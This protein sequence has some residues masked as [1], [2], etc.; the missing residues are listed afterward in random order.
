[1]S[2]F[3][4]RNDVDKKCKSLNSWCEQQAEIKNYI[5][6]KKTGGRISSLPSIG[7]KPVIKHNTEEKYGARRKIL[8][9]VFLV[10]G[11]YAKIIAGTKAEGIEDKLTRK[12]SIAY[13]R[14][15][16]MQ[17]LKNLFSRK[18]FIDRIIENIPFN[19][20][21]T[22]RFV[23]TIWAERYKLGLSTYSDWYTVPNSLNV[24]KEEFFNVIAENFK[25][26]YRGK[27]FLRGVEKHSKHDVVDF[28]VVVEVVANGI[29]VHSFGDRDKVSTLIE[30]IRENYQPIETLNVTSISGFNDKGPIKTFRSYDIDT[31]SFSEDCF[32]PWLGSSVKQFAKEYDESESSVLLLIGERG[33]GKSTF[34]RTLLKEMKRSRNYVISSEAALRS[35]HIGPWLDGLGI[36]NLVA[37]EDADNFISKREDG[38]LNMSQILNLTEGVMKSN[39]KIIFSTN[40][41]SLNKVDGALLREGRTFKILTFSRL[42]KEE[43]MVVRA[44]K[45]KSEINLPE[46]DYTLAEALN[47]AEADSK[48]RSGESFG[49]VP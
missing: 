36:N 16:A 46:G 15:P 41:N 23:E 19:D 31:L 27:A 10:E 48:N 33:T 4:S 22:S 43:A 29:N 1:M 40:L 20:I 25:V 42:T 12:K 18:T 28:Y 3:N 39:I 38:N 45:G 35:N 32:Y 14:E 5:L 11:H 26:V 47:Y 6:A 21:D 37:I 8:P 9:E 49:F 44:V 24:D 7:K 30:N 34:I 2:I 13:F 17:A